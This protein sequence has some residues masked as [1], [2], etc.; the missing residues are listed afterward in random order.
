MPKNLKDIDKST[1]TEQA[2]K[3]WGNLYPKDKVDLLIAK[4]NS[5]EK[6]ISET[7]E[8]LIKLQVAKSKLANL[9]NALPPVLEKLQTAN[10]YRNEFILDY[11]SLGI[12]STPSHDEMD[13][14]IRQFTAALAS[15]A[16]QVEERFFANLSQVESTI[17]FLAALKDFYSSLAAIPDII[18]NSFFKTEESRRKPIIRDIYRLF[19]NIANNYL[20][21]GT[22]PS[23]LTSSLISP[24]ID[25]A[26][27]NSL[28]A[29]KKE[30]ERT[31][32]ILKNCR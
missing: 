27:F 10:S 4:A 21:T 2:L 25:Q 1:L 16:S 31:L 9:T 29:V 11:G 28:I 12:S 13:S 7:K 19:S 26:E 15:Y 23:T 8:H 30:A 14:T 5:L 6:S 3:A 18:Q 20:F 22:D 17:A 24:P 32:T